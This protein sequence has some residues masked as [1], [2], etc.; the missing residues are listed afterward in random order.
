[1]LSTPPAFVLS[2]D[3]T[4]HEC[5][6]HHSLKS[7]GSTHHKSGTTSRNKTHGSQRPRCVFFKGT[8]TN[9]NTVRQAGVSTYLA[10]TFGTLLSSQGTDA[11]FE[12]LSGPSGRFPPVLRVPDSI[13]YSLGHFR[14]RFP[15][16]I[17]RPAGSFSFLRF[18]LY[19]NLSAPIPS[20]SGIAVRP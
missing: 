10:L 1:M 19:Q 20:R 8:Q 3:Q 13:R 16:R 15:I 18:R 14:V 4:L 9:R 7:V 2:Q 11:S 6:T 12:S 17:P 5:F